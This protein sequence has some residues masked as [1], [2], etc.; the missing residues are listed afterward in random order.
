MSNTLVFDLEVVPVDLKSIDEDTQKYLLKSAKGD[1]DKESELINN[2]VFSPFTSKLVAVGMLE[3][4]KYFHHSKF[5]NVATLLINNENKSEPMPDDMATVQDD[6][7]MDKVEYFSGTEKEIITKFWELLK[8]RK[9][10]YF[11]TFNG[12]EFDCP[13]IMLRSFILGIK[14]SRNLMEKSDFYFKEYHTDLLKEFTYFKGSQNGAT[15]KYN[16]DFY[17][18]ALGVPSPKAEGI[19][20]ENVNEL[21]NTKQYY[22]IAN[23]CLRDVVAEAKLYKKWKDFFNNI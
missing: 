7:P 8:E 1:A 18:K 4:E 22:R 21:Y 11:V 14:P 15:R 19:T 9:Y 16:L 3:Y 12:R 17:C 6:T 13:Y 23:Y 10:D 2:L 5:D 20:G